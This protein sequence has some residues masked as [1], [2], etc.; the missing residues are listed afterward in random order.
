M[1]VYRDYLLLDE[2]G[3]KPSKNF[4][5][6]LENFTHSFKYFK[7]SDVWFKTIL[8]DDKVVGFSS[9]TRYNK[10][11]CE[12]F[13]LFSDDFYKINTGDLRTFIRECRRELKELK[14]DRVQASCYNGY[15][16]AKKLLETLGFKHEAT[17][18]KAAYN[19]KDLD[20]YSR[21]K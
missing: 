1:I 16:K 15:D 18:K 20:I 8:I 10:N 13:F 21:V 6:A 2:A 12:V 17:L 5:E 7:I 3:F 4:P 11:F 14:F 9:A 19:S